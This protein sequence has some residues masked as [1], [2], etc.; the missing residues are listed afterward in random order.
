MSANPFILIVRYKSNI[1]HINP[2]AIYAE[3]NI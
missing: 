2:P 1:L 3:L